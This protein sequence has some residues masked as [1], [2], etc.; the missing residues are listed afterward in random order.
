MRSIGRADFL[1]SLFGNLAGS[2]IV[3]SQ[4]HCEGATLVHVS[5]RAILSGMLYPSLVCVLVW[6][7]GDG[8]SATAQN[9][10]PQMPFINAGSDSGFAQLDFAQLYLDEQGKSAKDKEKRDRE[11]REL[12]ASGVLSALDVDAPNY[13]IDQFNRAAGLLKEQKS[14]EA[15]QYLKNAIAAYPKF[16]LAHINLGL[17]YLDQGD[18]A[19]AKGEFETSATLDDKFAGAFLNLGRMAL[20]VNDFA[21][22]QSELGK[23][24]SLRPQD[25]T[26]LATLAYAQHRNH[27]YKNALETIDRVHALDHRDVANVHYVGAAAALSLNDA[28]TAERELNFFLAEDPTNAFSPAARK[29][30]AIL[31]HNREVSRLA[32]SGGNLRPTI[33]ATKTTLHTFPNTQRLTEQLSSLGNEQGNQSC[34][35]CDLEAPAE[36]AMAAN[37]LEAISG[38]SLDLAPTGG[39]TWT[40]HKNVD[41]VALFF[42]VTRHGQMVNDLEASD[43]QILDGKK[44]PERILEFA[45]QSKLPLRLGLLVDTSGSVNEQFLFEKRA[46][47][48]FVKNVLSGTSDLGFIAGFSNGAT[49]TQ[50]FTSDQSQLASGIEKLANEGGTALFDAVSFACRK[51]AEFPDGDRV[52]RVLVVLSDGEDNSSHS[53]LKHAI[54]VAERTGVTIYTISTKQEMGDK[55]DADRILEA[56]AERSGGEAMFPHDIVSLTQAL[57]RLRA[58]IRSRYFVAYKAADFQPDGR[59]RAIRI[60]AA[61]NGQRLQVKAR[62]GYFA[63][64]ESSPR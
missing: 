45:P 39:A 27:L 1:P 2:A 13:A 63:R 21:T 47:A 61:K 32:A 44:P 35:D 50:D 14:K 12:I 3:F 40:L 29:H 59:Y 28:A 7:L 60:T 8:I 9:Y 62:K 56:L 6:L 25:A 57:G 23:A 41:E 42:A 33:A 38:L 15:I 24:A 30:L 37:D 31:V 26:I 19:N 64:L 48:A 22:A 51:L 16:V 5:S 58:F 49:V 43:V 20:S 52:A 53:T 34:N 17:A 11:N 10:V 46:A 18:T 55:T 36:M 4:F 54:E